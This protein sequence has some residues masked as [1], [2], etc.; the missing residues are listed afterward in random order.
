MIDDFVKIHDKFS[1]EIKLKF[2]ARKKLRT[3]DFSVNTW[4]FIP[5]GLDINRHTYSK[6]NFYRDLRS[7][8]RLITPV[9]LLRDIANG[10]LSPIVMLSK[11]MEAMASEPTRTKTAAYE[12]HIKMFLSIL[13]SSLRDEI[14]HAINNKITDDTAYLIESYCSAVKQITEK[15]RSLRRI[16]N[17]PTITENTLNY[18]LFGDEFL[19]NLV[20]Q[21]TFKLLSGLKA[22]KS[23]LKKAQLSA[24][25]SLIKSEIAYRKEKGY[26]T[27]EKENPGRNRELIFRFSLLKKYAESELFLKGKKKRDG[28]LVEQIYL[29]LAAGISMIFATAIAFSFQQKY[30][31]FTMP[32]FVALVISYMM[33]D[34]IKELGRYYFAHKLGKRYFD[35]KTDITL[36]NQQI[37][38]SKEA[39][40]FIPNEK[41]PSQVMKIRDR[42]TILEANNRFDTEKI[43]LYRKLV[44][45]N[46]ES[47]DKCSQYVTA[48]MNDIVRLNVMNYVQK[49][50]NPV[51]PLFLP[52]DENGF[53]I[54]KGERIYYINL[55][56]QFNHEGE[57]EYRRYRIVLN[58]KGIRE[59]ESFTTK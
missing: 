8:I 52:D 1:V 56:M 50:D 31:N 42:S 10:E 37:G 40:D 28:L 27:I 34:R 17:T 7:N 19:S 11:A 49:M 18:Y 26:P 38:F 12:Y 16:I 58:R 53:Q 39:M 47:L 14:T 41:V 59:I 25:T 4:I 43:I 35:H 2:L 30:G 33:K 45:L 6:E 22:E 51:V 55:V 29:S 24:L 13:K 23:P 20:E 54:Y 46:R 15:Y 36:N 3:S 32:F 21:H 48:G 5:S 9:Y 44:R 57:T